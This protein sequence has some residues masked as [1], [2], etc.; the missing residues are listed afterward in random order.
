MFSKCFFSN[1]LYLI[2]TFFHI[3]PFQIAQS[4]G[5]TAGFSGCFYGKFKELSG[6]VFY[7]CMVFLRSLHANF[8][9]H[10]VFSFF[11]TILKA[12]NPR[13]KEDKYGCTKISICCR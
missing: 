13:Q 6:L 4:T 5:Y 3:A 12:N 8:N 10:I 2:L 7:C 9:V 1:Y 11:C